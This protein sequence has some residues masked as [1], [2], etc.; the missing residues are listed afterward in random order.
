MTVREAA[1]RYRER[2]AGHDQAAARTITLAWRGHLAELHTRLQALIREMEEHPEL[3][4]P[5]IRRLASYQALDAEILRAMTSVGVAAADATIRGQA[6]AID[7]SL[8]A[9]R[10]LTLLQGEEEWTPIERLAAVSLGDTAET[11]QLLRAT[12]SAGGDDARRTLAGAILSR[13]SPRRV[14]VLMNRAFGTPLPRALTISRT[15]ILRAAREASRQSY[16]QNRHLLVGWTW[17][18]AMDDRTC[19]YCWS[20]TGTHHPVTDELVSHPNCRCVMVPDTGRLSMPN[21]VEAFGRLSAARQAKILGPKAYA[22]YKSGE[23]TLADLAGTRVDP[24]W[25]EVGYTRSVS[26][27][28]S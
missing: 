6:L 13:Q 12:W 3:A 19:P 28:R 18:S 5:A 16:I 10:R 20:Q 7:T 24:R 22:A 23:I 15:E 27:A 14:A 21:G 26:A 8:T 11:I 2:L 17:L 9:A 25:G 1:E 4:Y